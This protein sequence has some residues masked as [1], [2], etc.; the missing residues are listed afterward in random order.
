MNWIRN[1]WYRFQSWRL[2]RKYGWHKYVVVTKH[3][4]LRSR[5]ILPIL[6]KRNSDGSH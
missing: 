1:A 3:E 5:Y 2:R 6:F 4:P